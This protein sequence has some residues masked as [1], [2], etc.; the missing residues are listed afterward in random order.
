MK[1]DYNKYSDNELIELFK[2]D[3]NDSCFEELIERYKNIIEGKTKQFYSNNQF[4]VD[5]H[6]LNQEAIIAFYSSIFTYNPD[7]HAKFSTFTSTCIENHL[8]NFVKKEKRLSFANLTKIDIDNVNLEE[9]EDDISNNSDIEDEIDI[10]ISNVHNKL[11]N[12][13]RQLLIY[14]LEGKSYKEIANLLE[15][16]PK[17]VDNTYQ[18]I[19]NKLKSRS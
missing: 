1:Y 8:I 9:Y 2:Q 13:E 10:L 14:K 11:N 16:K 17:D 7:K 18:K 4:F 19:K 5:Y 3:K 6:D 12:L 15:I